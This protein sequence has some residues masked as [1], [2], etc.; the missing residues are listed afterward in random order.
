MQDATAGVY[1][2]S[3]AA[4]R[5]AARGRPRG[6]RGR[7][8]AGRSRTHDRPGAACRSWVAPACPHRWCCSRRSTG[9]ASATASGSRSRA[10]SASS[11]RMMNRLTLEIVRDNVRAIVLVSDPGGA[12]TLHAGRPP[13]SAR[14]AR[15]RL[16]LQ[17]PADRASRL[18]AVARLTSRVWSRR[19]TDTP[20]ATIARI[21]AERGRAEFEA[22]VRAAGV[23]QAYTPGVSLVLGSGDQ[24][25]SVALGHVPALRRRAGRGRRAFPR[26]PPTRGLAIEDATL[27]R[28]RNGRSRAPDAALA[29][30]DRRRARSRSRGRQRAHARAARG[31]G[32]LPRPGRRRGPIIYVHDGTGAVYVYAPD[33]ASRTQLGDLVEV[34]GETASTRSSV[35]VDA[36]TVTRDRSRA[37]ATRRA[38]L[39]RHHRHRPPRRAVGRSDGDGEDG[40]RLRALDALDVGSTAAPLRVE[41]YGWRRSATRIAWWTP[42]SGF[43]AS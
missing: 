36:S 41:V 6:R 9:P 22:P 39:G 26:S 34:E 4:A 24:R 30:V 8:R 2:D 31:A 21:R 1:L 28:L 5:D 33:A 17:G 13:A 27:T 15:R 18:C 43:A 3:L 20:L 12:T 10:S 19:A 42:A 25:V 16:Q 32:R 11:R 37:A 14:R 7:H 29:D 40:R 23:V 38:V 35:F